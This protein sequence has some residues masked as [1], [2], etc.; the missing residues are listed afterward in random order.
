MLTFLLG[1][2]LGMVTPGLICL[3]ILLALVK[4]PGAVEPDPETVEQ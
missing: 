3:I 1:F 2:A 4:I